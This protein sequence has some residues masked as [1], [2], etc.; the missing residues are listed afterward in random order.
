[1]ELEFDPNKDRS[2]RDKHGISL[3]EAEKMD[4]AAA[5]LVPDERFLS[6]RRHR[7]FGLIDGRLYVLVFTMRGEVLRAISLRKA[8]RR[9]VGRYGQSTQIRRS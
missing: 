8:N 5:I 6:E 4:L 1:M 7:A 2:N 9:E 3:A